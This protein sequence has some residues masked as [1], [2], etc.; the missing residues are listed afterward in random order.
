MFIRLIQKI[1]FRTSYLIVEMF[2][3]SIEL[4]NWC[5]LSKLAKKHNCQIRVKDSRDERLLP[6]EAMEKNDHVFLIGDGGM[7]KSMA[8][9][10]Y[11]TSCLSDRSE[12]KKIC[13]Y[14]EL[15]RFAV[16][17]NEKRENSYQGQPVNIMGN[18][19]VKIIHKYGDLSHCSSL[20]DFFEDENCHKNI[21][22]MKDLFTRNNSRREYVLLVDGYNEMSE[23]RD[24]TVFKSELE[25]AANDWKNVS[26]VLTSRAQ[27]EKKERF[28]E[29]L[30]PFYFVG[31][32]D[33][34]VEQTLKTSVQLSSQQ[35]E[36]LKKDN[37]WTILK[38]P[39]FLNIY[40]SLNDYSKA[41]KIHTRGELLDYYVIQSERVVATNIKSTGMRQDSVH[42]ERRCF[43]T[44]F[45]L[46][47][48]ANYMDRNKMS[49]LPSVT[50]ND[51]IID[52][53]LLF[54]R[55]CAGSDRI[56]VY[57]SLGGSVSDK[58]SLDF[59]DGEF[60]KAAKK[61]H[62]EKESGGVDLTDA[63]AERMTMKEIFSINA[64]LRMLK[65][66]TGFCCDT[67]EGKIEF[68]HQY[69]R[70][71]FAAKHI[72]NILNTAQALREAGMTADDQLMFTIDNSL[73]YT[74]SDDVCLLLSEIEGDYVN[75]PGYLKDR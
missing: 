56:S 22:Q 18:I 51:K 13:L 47:F 14:L 5:N 37:I 21:T 63:A 45:S 35:V 49:S 70:D 42:A 7:G 67:S 64:T 38:T 26:I 23:E 1:S 4:G 39:M 65:D 74:W 58:A 36:R 72:Q 9:Y 24:R 11:W 19:A 68:T 53:D 3:F 16:W 54:L 59:D 71:Y 46:P 30:D 43:I 8:V 50:L 40:C 41:D 61:I 2:F 34:D 28:H 6:G 27:N 60:K 66:E 48:A 17:E 44:G 10:D 62:R 55:S 29:F 25:L 52:G 75:K 12:H 32:P 57:E 33:E 73:D 15:S 31:I 69:F 20:K